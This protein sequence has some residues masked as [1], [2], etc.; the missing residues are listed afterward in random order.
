[1]S[2]RFDGQGA[3]CFVWFAVG[4]FV[5]DG[6]AGK[7]VAVVPNFFFYNEICATHSLFSGLCFSPFVYLFLFYFYL[8]V[9]VWSVTAAGFR[10]TK[11]VLARTLLKFSDGPLFGFS[12]SLSSTERVSVSANPRRGLRRDRGPLFSPRRDGEST[13]M[14]PGT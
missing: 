5:A 1:M 13:D 9:C 2:D 7:S 8:P 11:F 3:A 4:A 12:R 10:S 6:P 14:N